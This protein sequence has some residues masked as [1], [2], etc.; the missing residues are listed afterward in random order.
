MIW[1]IL[2]L[3]TAPFFLSY[4]ITLIVRHLANK[5]GIGAHPNG[6]TVHLKFIP[7]LGGLAVYLAF[8]IGVGIAVILFPE[9]RDGALRKFIGLFIGSSL[10]MGIGIYDDFR[11]ATALQKFTF[12][13]IGAIIVFYLGFKIHYISNPFGEGLD[14]GIFAMP[15]TVFWIVGMSNAINQIDGLD[16]LAAGVT[17]I[18]S[19]TL[20]AITVSMGNMFIVFSCL[21]L[22]GA[23]LG[24]LRYNFNPASIFMGDTGSLFLGFLLGCL[25]I[26]EKFHT[27]SP[28]SILIPLILLGIPIVDTLLK[29]VRRGIY[30]KNPLIADRDHIHHRALNR[31]YSHKQT[32]LLFYL[33]NIILGVLAFTLIYVQPVIAAVIITFILLGILYI[34]NNLGYVK[35]IFQAYRKE[36]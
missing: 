27:A 16:G 10:V 6:R 12:Q 32:V 18:V 13:I 20:I 15:V 21:I 9:M 22:L 34:L 25:T 2:L 29:I 33:A 24:F 31:G 36:R 35:Y 1:K 30:G 4:F 3:F 19:I 14:L 8:F 23:S 28:V 26:E 17:A 7:C 5:Y 11:A